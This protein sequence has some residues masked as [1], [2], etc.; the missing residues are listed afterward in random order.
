MEQAILDAENIRLANGYP[1][2]VL[3]GYCCININ[4]VERLLHRYVMEQYL[5]RKLLPDEIVHHKNG[6]KLDNRIENLELTTRAEHVRMHSTGRKASPELRA[7]LSKAHTGEVVTEATKEKMRKA[8]IG[9]KHRPESTEKMR[10]S[11]LRKE[12]E[13]LGIT[14]NSGHTRPSTDPDWIHERR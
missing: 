7:K 9:R 12:C 14:V 8:A 13:R 1:V 2:H 11:A 6:N 5:G 3:D 4:G 10:Q